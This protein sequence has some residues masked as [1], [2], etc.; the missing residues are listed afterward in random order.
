MDEV[1]GPKRY[2]PWV[3]AGNG[4]GSLERGVG[5]DHK[6]AKLCVI[7][8]TGKKECFYVAGTNRPRGG[9]ARQVH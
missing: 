3:F 8:Y 2:K 1:D 5:D 9:F 7:V 4:N 6:S